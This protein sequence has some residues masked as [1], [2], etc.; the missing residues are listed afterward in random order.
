MT[1]VCYR[2]IESRFLA[3]KTNWM[4]VLLSKKMYTL[5]SRCEQDTELH[6]QHVECVMPMNIQAK[7]SCR[8]PEL[9][10]GVGERCWHRR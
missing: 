10:S 8:Q 5:R 2:E 9:S 3:S 7:T 4:V 6:F 1:S